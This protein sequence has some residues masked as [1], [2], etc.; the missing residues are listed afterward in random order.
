MRGADHMKKTP[1]LIISA[2]FFLLFVTGSANAVNPQV[3]A[4]GSHTVGL[5]ADG[6]VVAVG[7]NNSGQCNV[8]S[9]SGIVQVAASDYHTVGLKADGS[10]VA[11]GDNDYGQCKVS[12]WSGIVQVAAGDFHT[13]GLKADGSVVAVG[14][15]EFGQCNLLIWDLSGWVQP[16]TTTTTT[17]SPDMDNDGVLNTADNCPTVYNSAQQDADGD[18]FGD[19][20]DQGNR[21]AVL[22]EKARKVFIFDLSGN[23][24][25]TTDFSSLGYPYFMRDAGSSGWLLKGQSGSVWKIWHIDSAGALR[26]TFSNAYIGPGPYYS[27]ADSSSKCNS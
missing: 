22:D 14:S 25:H 15:N 13:V 8:S 10:V 26:N 21:F 20:C 18:G 16:P 12:S 19:V 7:R 4:G 1:F 11:V 6:S 24:L 2:L 3:E 9:W 5:K 27:G 23:L 17:V